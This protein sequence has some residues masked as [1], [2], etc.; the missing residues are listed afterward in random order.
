MDASIYKESLASALQSAWSSAAAFNVQQ[1][2]RFKKQ[3]DKT[4]LPPLKIS[5]G[6]RVEHPHLV[7]TS[8]SSPQSPPNRVH[9][10]QERVIA[11]TSTNT[12]VA[13]FTDTLLLLDEYRNIDI[14]RYVSDSALIEG[15]PQTPIE[16]HTILKRLP[17]DYANKLSEEALQTC[18]KYKKGRALLERFIIDHD[19]ATGLSEAERDE[20]R[21]AERHISDL[22][23]DAVRIMFEVRPP[24]VICITT[25]TLFNSISADG[26]FCGW[27]DSFTTLIGDE[28]SQIP[29]PALVALATH[30]PRILHIYIGDTRQLEPHARCPRSSNRTERDER[31]VGTKSSSCPSNDDLPSTSI[32]ERTPEL[33][34]FDHQLVNGTQAEERQLFLSSVR[35]P[36]PLLPFLFVDVPGES[37]K[38]LSGSHSNSA[39]SE[40][41]RQ[42]VTSLLRKNVP[43]A[44]IAII[45]FYK[46][47]SRSLAH[48]AS[49][50]SVNLHTVDSVQGREKDIVILLTT[51]TKFDPSSGEFLNDPH[52][53]N[54]A[55][56]R[57]RHG[58]F[59]LGHEKSLAGLSF[60]ADILQW[61]SNR[62]AVTTAAALPDLLEQSA[63]FV[64]FRQK[65]RRRLLEEYSRQRLR[66][67]IKLAVRCYCTSR[68]SP[69]GPAPS[70]P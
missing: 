43:P 19:L 14:L 57:C 24:A 1:S 62:R 28:A 38:S 31:F 39:D 11:T 69:L 12:A 25:A 18:R 4:G 45:V 7:I 56:S 52:R 67:T 9:M 49:A 41:C 21:L 27:F 68:S 65:A 48:F 66:P 13:Q 32:I 33:G 5:A 54:V 60:W 22:T 26:I 64:Y 35:C 3:Y 44:S 42:V 36:N 34:F 20:Y 40:V 30:L 70:Q 10:N 17:V 29:E 6:D 46:E 53:L 51:R 8:V 59:V 61:A 23:K 63:H 50:S 37:T 47:Q 16:L 15:A 58:Q 55:L 2:A